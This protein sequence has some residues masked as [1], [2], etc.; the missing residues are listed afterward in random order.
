MKTNNAMSLARIH[1]DLS[2]HFICKFTMLS[3]NCEA[4]AYIELISNIYNIKST[5]IENQ[6]LVINIA[7][8]PVPLVYTKIEN[9]SGGRAN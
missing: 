6:S 3:K 5:K 4:H 7:H 9:T 8:E 2:C 1:P